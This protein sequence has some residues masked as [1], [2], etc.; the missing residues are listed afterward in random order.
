[1][2]Y[3]LWSVEV[4]ELDCHPDHNKGPDHAPCACP[5]HRSLILAILQYE[6]KETSV[7]E[8]P[9]RSCDTLRCPAWL[10]ARTCFS[11]GSSWPAR[12]S[13]QQLQEPVIQPW[14]WTPFLTKYF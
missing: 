6:T 13:R 2:L 9:C 8:L 1:M 11:Q 12:S 5:S 14:R 10:P 7:P 4:L 3:D